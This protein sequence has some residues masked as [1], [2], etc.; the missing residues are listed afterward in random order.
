MQFIDHCSWVST[1]SL[2]RP[3]RCRNMYFDAGYRFASHTQ[4][5]IV[6]STGTWLSLVERCTGG[7]EVASSNLV[8]PIFQGLTVAQVRANL[9]LAVRCVKPFCTNDVPKCSHRGTAMVTRKCV[10][11]YL[12]Y[13]SRGVGK[14]V[15]HGKTYYLPGEYGTDGTRVASCHPWTCLWCIANRL[16]HHSRPATAMRSRRHTSPGRHADSTR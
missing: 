5:D 13:R 6:V 1:G 11:G 16:H 3:V 2:K 4:P 15:I 12:L 8:V 7:A 14:V 10:P 9:P